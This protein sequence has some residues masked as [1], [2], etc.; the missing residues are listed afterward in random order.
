MSKEFGAESLIL[1]GDKYHR[2][3][4]PEAVIDT[5][6]EAGGLDNVHLDLIRNSG[7]AVPISDILV[8]LAINR[9]DN[10]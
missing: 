1:A 10:N 8:P 9:P 4:V 2:R 3:I 5:I 7:I 6:V